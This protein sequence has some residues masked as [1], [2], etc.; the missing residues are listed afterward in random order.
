MPAGVAHGDGV[1]RHGTVVH[2]FVSLLE[3]GVCAAEEF[4]VP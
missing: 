4:F 1:C 2:V 3:P